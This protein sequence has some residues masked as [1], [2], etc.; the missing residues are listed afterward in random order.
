MTIPWYIHGNWKLESTQLTTLENDIVK[1]DFKQKYD[2]S[3]F[4]TTY[5]KDLPSLKFLYNFYKDRVNE[6]AKSQFFLKYYLI[7]FDFWVQIYNKETEHP[8]HDHFGVNTVISFVHFLR[9]VKNNCFSFSDGEQFLIPQQEEGDLLVFPSY[10]PHQI[11]SP[12]LDQNRVVV[13]GNI[14]INK[15]E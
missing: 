15:H 14:F 10:V 2:K 9:P 8:V 11:K 7:G 13:A 1:A 12:E 5:N 6:I 3:D 4:F